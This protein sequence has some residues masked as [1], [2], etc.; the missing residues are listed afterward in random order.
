MSNSFRAPVKDPQASLRHSFDWSN[1]LAGDE[2]ITAVNVTAT[3][4]IT[5]NQVTQQSGVVSYTISGG[6]AGSNYALTCE[7]TTSNGQ[8]DQR[9]VEYM[10]RER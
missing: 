9:S 10:V 7:I 2:T 1:W 4:G 8:I 6:T 3:A 5:V